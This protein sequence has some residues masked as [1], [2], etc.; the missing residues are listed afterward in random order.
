MKYKMPGHHILVRVPECEKICQA[1]FACTDVGEYH[2]RILL[3][4]YK[5]FPMIKT[6]KLAREIMELLN[7]ERDSV[8]WEEDENLYFDTVHRGQSVDI[9]AST[10]DFDYCIGYVNDLGDDINPDKLGQLICSILNGTISKIHDIDLA[11]SY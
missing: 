1:V 8:N 5:I 4:P 10:K 7:H 2:E 3:E 11:I 9:F 6:L